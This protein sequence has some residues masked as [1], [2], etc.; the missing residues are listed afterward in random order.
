MPGRP[1]TELDTLAIEPG[2]VRKVKAVGYWPGAS[3]MAAVAWHSKQRDHR[4]SG[5]PVSAGR[6]PTQA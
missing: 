1:D 3:P 4:R 2:V 6:V 5:S